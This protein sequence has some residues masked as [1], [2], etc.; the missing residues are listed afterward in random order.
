MNGMGPL[1]RGMQSMNPMT[2]RPGKRPLI[3]SPQPH[4]TYKLAVPGRKLKQRGKAIIDTDPYRTS[5]KALQRGTNLPIQL[6]G[7]EVRGHGASSASRARQKQADQQE[8]INKA[9]RN[10][11]K[12]PRQIR[13]AG[14]ADQEPLM[15][16][17]QVNNA[18]LAQIEKL[19]E[20]L[21][22]A[23]LVGNK[24][25]MGPP[26]GGASSGSGSSG[27]TEE[28]EIAKIRKLNKEVGADP[29]FQRGNRKRPTATTPVR[30]KSASP[31]VYMPVLDYRRKR[32]PF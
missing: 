17:A 20:G 2:P 19:N 3:R 26:G 30:R 29:K 1:P 13:P 28:E 22:L 11:N 31:R 21:G 14:V 12:A 5:L 18:D 9:L 10:A 16:Q 24:G 8:M 32:Y 27:M 15:N 23:G 7:G 4:T 25:D 6:V